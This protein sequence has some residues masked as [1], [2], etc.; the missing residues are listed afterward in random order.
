M[1]KLITAVFVSIVVILLGGFLLCFP[2]FAPFATTL[3]VVGGVCFAIF[4]ALAFAV[5]DW[6]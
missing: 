4:G 2:Q 3:I 5:Y 6:F 1:K